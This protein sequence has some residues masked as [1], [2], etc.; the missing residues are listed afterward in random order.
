MSLLDFISENGHSAFEKSAKEGRDK[1]LDKDF[2]PEAFGSDTTNIDSLKTPFTYSELNNS[3]RDYALPDDMVLNAISR[4]CDF[5]NLPEVPVYNS[6]SVC[7]WPKDNATLSDDVFGFNRQE[8]INLGIKGEDSLTLIYTHECAHRALQGKMT[9]AWKEELACDFFSG[10]NAGMNNI[11]LDNVEAALGSTDG[12]TTHPHGA[13]RAQF[14]EAGQNLAQ[15]MRQ[16]NEDI[17]FEKCLSKFEQYFQEK[18]G[19]IAEYR[20]RFDPYYFSLDNVSPTSDLEKG[21]VN[22]KDWHLDEARKAAE[23]GDQKA[24]RDHISAANMCSK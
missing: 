24:A 16:N 12:G 5:F 23:R 1:S 7:V 4:A 9:D 10:L 3:L 2:S 19:L 6:E 22:D 13:L 21:F 11:N 8:L 20:S 18:S 17:T 14:I 15:E